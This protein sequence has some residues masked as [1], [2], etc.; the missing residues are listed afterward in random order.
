M[1]TSPVQLDVLDLRHFNA[2]QLQPL[3]Q[4]EGELWR[5]RLL[6]DY[7][8]S[9]RLLLDYMNS[10]I[11]PGFAA[12][13]HGSVRGYTFGVYE[14]GKAILGDVYASTSGASAAGDPS[15]QVV[16]SQLLAHMLPLLQN[17]PGIERVESQLLLHPSGQHSDV[18]EQ[19]G[20]R[21]YPRLLMLSQI[22]ALLE[23]THAETI[24]T[25]PSDLLLRPW[26]QSDLLLAGELIVRGYR[27]HLDSLI[28]SQY[29]SSA[30]AMRFLHN[31]IQFP[32]CGSF[33]ASS[34]WM[35][36]DKR[37]GL[38]MGMLLCSLVSEECAHI[39]QL[40][41]APEMRRRGLATLMTAW[42]ADALARKNIRSVTLTVTEAN[43]GA[44]QLY[45]QLGFTVHHRF[46][47]M[48][49]TA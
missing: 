39:T 21:I 43:D 49:W 22:A 45:R 10:R 25:P 41:I 47:A 36:L 46:D 42:C 11:L 2:R 44:V 17:S 12:V 18:F 33:D 31:I 26:Q 28:N 27:D 38:L 35:I 16:E 15:A 6:W 5:K 19:A 34:S 1:T 14:A 48:V 40:C 29:L 32:G 24:E 23:H 30:G 8:Q 9:S 7:S 13:D 37:T 3:L 4:E 20:F